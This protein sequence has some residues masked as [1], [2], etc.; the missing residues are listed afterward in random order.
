MRI[1]KFIN[2]TNLTKR[3]SIAQDMLKHGVIFIND[4]Q[5]KPSKDVKIGDIIEFKMLEKTERYKVLK[6]PSTKSIPKSA[7]EEYV[8]QL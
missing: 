1:D 8:E 4:K 3:R 7:Q 5:A 2:T 6:L